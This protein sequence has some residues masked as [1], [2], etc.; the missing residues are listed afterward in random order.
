MTKPREFYI[1]LPPCGCSTMASTTAFQAVYDGSIPFT[2]SREHISRGRA[3]WQLAGPITL[4]SP[5]RI[6]PP[7]Q[8]ANAAIV[9]LARTSPCQG[10]GRQFKSGLPLEAKNR[11]ITHTIHPSCMAKRNP[12]IKRVSSFRG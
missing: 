12:F 5:V 6:R 8:V 7:Q 10:E 9:Q 1:I 11:P 3:A 4:R 2:R